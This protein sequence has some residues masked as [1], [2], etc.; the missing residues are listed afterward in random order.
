MNTDTSVITLGDG[1]TK[2][3]AIT[4]TRNSVPTNYLN[5]KVNVA[6]SEMAN[7]AENARDYNKFNPFIRFARWKDSKVKDCM[8]FFNAVIFVRERDEDISTHREFQDTNYH[9]YALCNVGDSKKTDATRVNDKN[10]PKEHIIEITDYNVPLAEFPTGVDGVCPESEWKPGNTAYDNLYSEYKYKDGKF[11]SFGAESYEF[12]Y[13]MKGIT[14]EQRQTNIDVWREMYKFIVTS[15]DEVFYSRLKEWFVVNSVLF[16]YLFTETRVMVDSRAK[17][18]FWHYGKVYISESEVIEL[19]EDAGGYII[20]NEQAAIRNGYRYDLTQ[21]YDGDTSHGIGNTGKL[22]IPY[23]TEDVDYYVEDDPESG[24]IFRAAKSTFFCRLR[25]LFKSEMQAMYVDRENVNA[26]SSSRTI[27]QWDDSQ[28]QFPEELL[29]LHYQRLYVRTYQGA[30]IDNSIPKLNP[31]FLEEMMNGRKKYQRR[32]FMRNNELYFATKYFGKTATQDQIMMRFNNPVGAAIAPDFT[33]YIT[34][35]S[36]MYIGTSFGN[37]TPTNFRA[38]AGV[39]YTIPCSIE[40]GTADITLIYGASFIQGIGNLSKCYVGDNDFSKCSRLQVLIMGSDEEGY[41]NP[42]MTKINLGNNKLLEYLDVRKIIGLNSVVDLSQ[43]G[44]LIELHAE[45]SGA[46]GVIFANGG[47]LEK[48]HIPAVTSLTMKN[49]NYLKEFEIESLDNLTTLII[50]NTPFIDSE[51]MVT[52]SELLKT[53]RLIGLNWDIDD[54]SILEK[55]YPL[56]GISNTGGEINNSVLAGYVYIPGIKEYDY[57]KYTDRWSDLTI[58]YGA[59]TPQFV[60]KFMNGEKVEDTQ[61]IDQYGDA[62]DPIAREDNPIAVPVK[63]STADKDYTFIGW[64]KTFT[65]VGSNLVVNAVFEETTRQYPAKYVQTFGNTTTTLQEGVADYG[66]YYF[67]TGETPTYTA[68]EQYSKFYLFN[69]WDK[70]G[71][72][73]GEKVI[74]AVYDSCYISDNTYFEGKE[75]TD[76]SAVELYALTRL[77]EDGRITITEDASGIGYISG[78][79]VSEGDSFTFNMG[80]DYDYDDLADKTFT[81]IDVDA[82]RTFTGVSGD[83]Y[84]TE[85]AVLD[86][87]RD[88]VLAVDYEFASGNDS[89]AV[90]MECYDQNST[91]GFKLSYVN[92]PT[93]SWLSA[94]AECASGTNREMIVLRHIAGD[95]QL[96]VYKSDLSEDAVGTITLENTITSLTTSYSLIFGCGRR[97][98]TTYNYYAKGT[99]HWAKLWYTDLG[100]EACQNLASY[101]HENVSL[102]IAGF[103]RFYLED[104]EKLTSIDFIA[105]KALYTKKAISNGSNVNGFASATLN[106][107]LNNRFYLG[108]PLWVKQLAKKFKVKSRIGSKSSDIS[109]SYCYVAIPSV[110]ELINTSP[111]NAS[112]YTLESDAVPICIPHMTAEERIIEDY[113]GEA[114]AY[115]TR[116]PSDSG[117]GNVYYLY[118]NSSGSVQTVG[119]TTTKYGVVIEI[120]F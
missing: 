80:H 104:G 54:N 69:R 61:Y 23:G 96:Y 67:Y 120:S 9:F 31:R 43:C 21:F 71:Y 95:P 88:F 27:K 113:T 114:V 70:S 5:C 34:P 47:K 24:Y 87:N 68:E 109:F 60:V 85:I 105:D 89:G 2:V 46:T 42:F 118:I 99:V 98:S 108:L 81:L 90:L 117:A 103:N 74:T 6:S 97:T 51:N 91:R 92:N 48:A 50:E 15:S 111:Y 116:S 94:S 115:W 73:D 37:V 57:Y 77:V 75:L 25:D 49:L 44:N 63:E 12:R 18:S 86:M 3:S 40:S 110:S 55:V 11:K 29:R 22:N 16:Y 84:D 32:M 72:I 65:N 38:K 119:Q 101:I 79:N 30:S 45:G 36:N 4:L 17:N 82:P 62:V 35:Y 53:L 26:W 52:D 76:L 39:E 28:N 1:V 33:L 64:D 78:S 56:R 8:E 19:G 107:W 112:P 14:N 13:E 102:K 20:D 106:T 58:E 83:Y 93:I 66:T 100:E 7:N 10:D 41:S 59:M